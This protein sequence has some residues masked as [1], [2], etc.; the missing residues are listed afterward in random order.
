MKRALVL[1][2]CLLSAA[3]GCSGDSNGPTTPTAPRTGLVAEF[4]FSGDGSDTSGNGYNGTVNGP[5]LVADRFGHDASAYNFD[6]VNDVITTTATNHF[7]NGNLLSVSLWIKVAALPASLEYF[8]IC[9]DFG[10]WLDGGSL[11]LAI[12]VPATNSASGAVTAG[13]WH[14]LLGTYDGTNVVVY[15][16]GV[17]A[18]TTN[19][20]GN[21][22][23][24]NSALVFGTFASAYFAGTLDDVRIYNRVVTAAEISDLYHEGG[25]GL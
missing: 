10:V 8:V 18:Q 14:H 3:L 9:K 23:G 22:S 6:G 13:T 12:S 7:A 5:T 16:D 19:H 21:I 2:L 24:L 4:L 15:I 20:P 17:H 25:F 11:G 1:P